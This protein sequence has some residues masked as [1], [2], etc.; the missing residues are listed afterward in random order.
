MLPGVMTPLVLAKTAVR[1]V[2]VPAEMVGEAAAKLMMVGA[3]V[4]VTVVI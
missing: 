2:E 1:L 3:P 4:T